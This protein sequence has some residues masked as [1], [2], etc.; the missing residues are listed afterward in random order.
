MDRR[1]FF[2]ILG[3]GSALVAGK[4]L[5]GETEELPKQDPNALDNKLQ[6]LDFHDKF[7]SGY[8]PMFG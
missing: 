7:G 5:K 6:Q 4:K 1:N 2:K 8:L 3:L